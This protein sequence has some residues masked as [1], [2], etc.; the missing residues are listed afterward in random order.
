MSVPDL[1]NYRKDAVSGFLRDRRGGIVPD[2]V[3]PVFDPVGDRRV[4]GM[5]R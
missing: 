3:S 1:R 4:S 2:P 5:R